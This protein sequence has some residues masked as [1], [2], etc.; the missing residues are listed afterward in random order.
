[1]RDPEDAIDR[2]LADAGA[3]WRAAQPEPRPVTAEMFPEGRAPQFGLGWG[4]R[5]W[6]YVA[7]AASALALVALVAVLAPGLLSRIGGGG[8]TATADTGSGYLPAGL[9]T[10]PLTRPDPSFVPPPSYDG[11]PVAEWGH[12]WVGTND[13]WTAVSPD[14]D[15]WTDVT[16]SASGYSQ[17]T[18]WWS[19]DFRVNREQTPQIFVTGRRLDGP[20]AFG[21]GPGTN[22]GG[23]DIGSAMLVG[24]D[25]PTIGCWEL[26]ARYRSAELS[27]VVWVG[28]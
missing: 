25:V 10:C 15:N 19:D 8:S 28:Q 17:K 5:T 26:T 11:Q 6:A 21:F 22:A 27:I 24:V 3:Q 18:F 12:G 1:M 7:G 13:L 16:K 14:G 9:E 20:G 2:Q 4:G 23:S